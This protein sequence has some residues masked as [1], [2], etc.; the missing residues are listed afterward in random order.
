MGQESVESQRLI[1]AAST[2]GHL[3]ELV[4]QLPF[5][6]AADDSLWITFKSAQSE[7]LLAGR[8]VLHVPYVRPRDYRGVLRTMR[9]MRGVLRREHFDGAVSTGSA[10]ALGVLPV[11]R[12]AGIPATYIE[13]VCRVEGPSTTG[14]VLAATHA[15]QMRTQHPSWAGKQWH[16]QQSILATY[17]QRGRE[18]SCE[19]GRIF[20]TLGTIRGYRFDSL[21][22]AVL[23]SGLANENTVWQL[24]ETTGRIDL[25]GQVHQYL[26]PQEFARA[27]KAA[28]VVVTHAGVGTL[29]GLLDLGIYPVL[30]VRRAERGEHVD[31]HQAQIADLV[32]SLGIGSAVE[33][34]QLTA[35]VISGAA[36]R[37]IVNSDA[38]S[39]FDEL[40]RSA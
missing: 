24:G 35:S 6:N 10:I 31:N 11:A 21:I 1:L 3:F 25:P 18:R 23:A 15:A 27:S 13:S 39:K 29:L 40:M 32:N 28:D 2:G 4:R 8:R 9:V 22:D 14:R 33:V 16:L 7:E 37:E 26:T 30:V 17:A 38:V 36:Q 19:V 34:A 5:L 20:V 12:L